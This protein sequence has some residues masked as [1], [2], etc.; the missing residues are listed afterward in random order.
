MPAPPG[1]ALDAAID[2]AAAAWFVRRH[3][4][5]SRADEA[6]F[7][8]WLSSDSRH[9][10]AYEAMAHAWQSLDATS[11]QDVARLRRGIASPT[12]VRARSA[13]P[14]PAVDLGRRWFVPRMAFAGTAFAVAGTGALG[15]HYWAHVPTF[16]QRFETRRGEMQTVSLPDGSTLRLDTDT[17]LEAR[18]FRH[19]REVHIVRGQAM[20]SVASNPKRP[21][22]V[23]ARDVTVTVVGTRFTVRRTDSG[24]ESG[25]VLVEV[26]DG[27]VRVGTSS[28]GDASPARLVELGAGQAVATDGRGMLGDVLAI[29]PADVG[30]WQQGRVTFDNTTVLR[31]LQEFERYGATRIV[32]GDPAVGAMR[33]TG[34]F[35]VRQVERFVRALPRVLPVRLHTRGNVTEILKA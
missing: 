5:V 19:R 35:D 11:V 6:A 34:S 30:A 10:A 2:E 12:P 25:N 27:R 20:F 15:W 7:Q 33:L 26:Q 3:G 14:A 18:L 23:L 22:E 1:V 21:F 29:Q 13:R 8:G 28:Q 16:S 32:V 31:A 9:R 24:L 17:Q 4:D